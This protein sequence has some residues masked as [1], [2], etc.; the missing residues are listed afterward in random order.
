MCL[1]P[2]CASSPDDDAEDNADN[3]QAQTT[4]SE[5]RRQPPPLQ[6]PVGQWTWIDVPESKCGNGEPTGLMVNMGTGRDLLI[7]LGGGGACWNEL[8]CTVLK[9]AS[10]IDGYKEAQFRAQGAYA[11]S[12]IFDRTASDNPF[13]KASFVYV[14]YCTGDI[15]AGDATQQFPT[16]G[17]TMHYAGQKNIAAFLDKI[18]PSFPKASHVTLAGS[19]AGGFG[20]QVNYWRVKQAFGNRQVDLI[21]DSGP[22]FSQV[23][24]PLYPLWKATWNME[25]ALPPG[26]TACKTDIRSIYSYYSQTYP[27]S[28]FALLSYEQDPT[29]SFFFQMPQSSFTEHLRDVTTNT[30]APLHNTRFFVTSGAGHTMLRALGTTSVTKSIHPWH[31]QATSIELGTWLNQMVDDSWRWQ[32]ATTQ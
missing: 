26:C 7:F 1:L 11:D 24:M 2:A 21:N 31:S 25:P 14:P 23:N 18:V 27:F 3:E 13:R 29:I 16:A 20:A 12:G 9:T 30:I 19:S 17:R 6:G 22:V 15:H 5:L 32:N 8:S 10:N 4:Q 28:R